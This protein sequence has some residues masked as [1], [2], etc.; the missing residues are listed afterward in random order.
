MFFKSLFITAVVFLLSISVSNA[1]T[2]TVDVNNIRSSEGLI[3]AVLHDGAEGFP[4][5]RKPLV[6][7]FTHAKEEGIT[8]SF[9]N[10]SEGSYAVAL[11]HD[12]NGNQEMDKNF[13]GIPKEGLGVSNDAK[14]SFGPPSFKDAAI[15]VGGSDLNIKISIGY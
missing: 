6:K 12:E 11:Y 8:M 14:G 9:P 13:I 3:V 15:Q 7:K 2:L 1:A 4:V 10:L 5:E